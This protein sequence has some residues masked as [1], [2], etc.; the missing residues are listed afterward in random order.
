MFTLKSKVFAVL[1]TIVCATAALA[2]DS[3]PLIDLLVKKGIINDQEGEDLRAELSKDFAQSPAGKLNLS[4]GLTELKLSGDVRVRYES[5]TGSLV[6]GDHLERDRFRY[7]F[8]TGLTGKVLNNWSWGVRLETA[9]G[10][11][12]SNVT[13]G[14]DAGPFA[15]NSD[16]VNIGQIWAQWT[17]TSELTFTGGRMPN[18]LVTTA[19]V[20]DADINPEGLA[21]SYKHR[22]GNLE[23][24]FTAAQF[25]YSAAGTQ[26]T[27]GT[28]ANVQDLFLFA[29]QGG[30]KYYVEGATT[31]L[32]VNPTF[33]QYVRNNKFNPA[34]FKGTFSATNAAAVNNLFVFDLPVEYNWVLNGVPVR[35]FGDFAINL[36]GKDRA[37]KWGRPDLDGENKA[38]QVGFQYGKAA[39]KGEWDA[40]VFY[41]STGAFALDT[42]LVD[43]DIWDSRTNMTG[44]AATGNYAL[45]AA[46]TFT[47]TL[48]NGERKNDALIAPGAGDIGSNNALDK[49]WLLQ[50]D[51]VVKF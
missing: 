13:M 42:N 20:W 16:T 9:T 1:A 21:E 25:L 24:S 22:D 45:G 46:T 51:L 7:R 27:F 2:Q 10:S 26:N 47:V 19:M 15:K 48:A 43:S 30:L 11:R 33:Y 38:W 3:G 37:R 31:F 50:A 5:R 6:S 4:S 18:P 36:D 34:A 35:A 32:Q 12:S 29:W 8:R 49:Y 39:N 23:Y 44:W 41:Q 17:P 28:A 14:D 40:K